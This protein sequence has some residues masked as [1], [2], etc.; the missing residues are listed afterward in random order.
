M[1]IDAC[2]GITCQ[3]QQSLLESYAPILKMHAK[4]YPL[5]RRPEKKQKEKN[6]VL[7][8]IEV[9]NKERSVP[10]PKQGEQ[11]PKIEKPFFLISKKKKL[12]PWAIYKN[13]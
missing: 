3:F 4:M 9:K 10:L 7:I 2:K 5:S 11:S 6:L 1:V 8:I 12:V 13:L